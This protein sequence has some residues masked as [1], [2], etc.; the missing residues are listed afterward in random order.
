MITACNAR[1]MRRRRSNSDGKN[2][3]ARSL[4]IWTSTSPA[5]VDTVLPIAVHRAPIAALVAAGAD[6]LG[7]FGFDQRLQPGAGQV[8][9]HRAGIG[10][11]DRI[12]L[13]EQ[14]R[15]VLGHRVVSLSSVTL[16]GN[17]LNTPPSPTP[18]PS[19]AH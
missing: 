7:G 8:G 9:E 3:P 19:T 1:S 10:G 18:K 14:G 6:R 13:G 11:L 17:S 16:V 15:M 5:A 2:D 12:D 4:G